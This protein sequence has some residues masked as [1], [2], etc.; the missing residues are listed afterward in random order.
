MDEVDTISST[1]DPG[2]NLSVLGGSQRGYMRH[3]RLSTSTV[4]SLVAVVTVDG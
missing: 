4:V 2:L 1:G 3:Q